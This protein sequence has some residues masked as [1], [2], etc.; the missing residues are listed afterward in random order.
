MDVLVRLALT[1]VVFHVIRSTISNI[2]RTEAE[3]VLREHVRSPAHASSS[4]A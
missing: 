4:Q 2:A 3:E 1:L